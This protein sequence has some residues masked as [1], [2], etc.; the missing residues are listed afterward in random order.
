MDKASIV[1]TIENF[2]PLKLQEEWDCSGWIVET[3][4]REVEK[5]MLCLTVTNEII[6]QAKEK[7]CDMI[8]SH[9]P[10]FCVPIEYRDIDIYC[11]H[12]NLDRTDGG[13]TDV[14]INTLGL[15]GYKIQ[16]GEEIPFVRY[17]DYEASI[18][19]FAGILSGISGNLRIIN[20]YK[21]KSVKKIAFCSGS[22][23]EFINEAYKNGADALVTGDIKFHTAVESPIVLFDVGHFESEVLVLKVFD[24]LINDMV[25]VIYA[26][27]ESPF[28]RYNVRNCGACRGCSHK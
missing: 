13:T 3:S 20:P 11:A 12:T 28:V 8:I 21:I 10:L 16:V 18:E 5:V 19:E 2:A 14:L 22:G 6:R 27:E 1:R 23:S 26:D 7:N 9:H 24:M 4:K 15:D 17:A 25:D